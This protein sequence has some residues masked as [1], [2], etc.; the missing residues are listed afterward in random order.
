MAELVKNAWQGWRLFSDDGKLAAA[1]MVS[2]LFLW[3]Y[4]K[5]VEQKSFL[6]YTT[7]VTLLCIFPFTAVLLERYQ[8]SIYGY[9]WIWSFVPLT[10]MVS[11]AATVFVAEVLR[12]WQGGSRKRRAL[13]VVFLV[14]ALVFCGGMGAEPRDGYGKQ[15]ERLQAE[16]LL[17]KVQ[18][19]LQGRQICLW[20]PRAVLE[21]A[22]AYDGGLELLYG[23]DMWEPELGAYCYDAYP[24]EFRS[25]YRWME[26]D[27]REGTAEWGAQCLEAAV[28]AEVSCILVPADRPA[29]TIGNFEEILGVQAEELE[30]YYLFIR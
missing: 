20:A 5:K 19:R 28:A 27:G 30:G 29:E 8:T 11:F 13:A 23:R 15:A 22:R 6:I 26:A 24:E 10:A 7:A 16:A 4:Y 9:Q 18:E 12:E 14:M 1:L 21:Y 3:V 2:L 17:Q 25:L